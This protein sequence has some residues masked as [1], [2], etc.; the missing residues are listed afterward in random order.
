MLYKELISIP[1]Q[2]IFQNYNPEDTY[3]SKHLFHLTG[4]TIEL[5]RS[6]LDSID[7]SKIHIGNEAGYDFPTELRKSDEDWIL[8]YSL[9][10][11]AN[12]DDSY[13]QFELFAIKGNISKKE[14]KG[15]KAELT[16]LY[17][18]MH[19]SNNYK[20]KKPHEYINELLKRNILM[21]GFCSC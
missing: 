9:E 17:K 7:I 3:Y 11:I 16:S 12:L 5:R 20:G 1:K 18:A 14:A 6:N 8:D 21:I 2:K 15:I 19:K 13:C 10:K 4:D